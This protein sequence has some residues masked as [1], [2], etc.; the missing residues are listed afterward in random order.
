MAALRKQCRRRRAVPTTEEVYRLHFA[1]EVFL[2]S[3]QFPLCA[4]TSLA[5]LP[6]A[7]LDGVLSYFLVGVQ[8]ELG[9]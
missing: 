7:L 5:S 1:F 9:Y 4:F 3:Y 2:M 6:T 8:L